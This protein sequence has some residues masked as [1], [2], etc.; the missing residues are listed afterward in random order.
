MKAQLKM[1]E[2]IGVLV[3]FFILLFAGIAF[4]FTA[5]TSAVQKEK[6]EAQNQYAYQLSLRALNLPELDCSF[7][8]T[9]RDNCVDS[10]KLSIF[11]KL[12]AQD[13]D[14]DETRRLYFPEF[15][16]STI[17]IK[18]IYP[19]GAARILYN[20]VLPEF[21]D[22]LTN[23]NPILIYHPLRDEYSFAFMEVNVYA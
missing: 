1:F 21:S 2:T 3:V 18:P 11:S 4:Y 23:K 12:L 16:Y 5:Q 6:R 17:T 10:Y 22:N 20:N 19:S 7:L 14:G 9:K 8:V 15:G 13:A